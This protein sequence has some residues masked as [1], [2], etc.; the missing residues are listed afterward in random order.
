MRF[1]KRGDV[2]DKIYKTK[3]KISTAGRGVAKNDHSTD[4]DTM[5]KGKGSGCHASIRQSP[6]A[7]AEAQAN[8]RLET[9]QRTRSLVS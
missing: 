6:L 1:Q 7:F 3:G 9:D 8:N 5:Q 4:R 2:V